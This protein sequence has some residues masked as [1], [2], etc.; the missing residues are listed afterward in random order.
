M[1]EIVTN[2]QT[3]ENYNLLFIKVT[4]TDLPVEEAVFTSKEALV[5]SENIV[6]FY[7]IC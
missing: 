3:S 2:G 7:D 4:F 1:R 6:N 5:S